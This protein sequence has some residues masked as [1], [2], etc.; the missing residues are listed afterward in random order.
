V[1]TELTRRLQVMGW[2]LRKCGP[3]LALEILLPGGTLFA[4][5]LFLYQRRQAAVEAG[6]TPAPLGRALRGTAGDVMATS[7]DV[8]RAGVRALGQ[9]RATV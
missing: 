9:V 5:L 4:L 3:Y 7:A 8:L 2:L 1:R 6:A